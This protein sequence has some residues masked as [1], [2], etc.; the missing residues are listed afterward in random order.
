MLDAVAPA[1]RKLSGGRGRR[2]WLAIAL[3]VL[4]A[5]A[6]LLAVQLIGSGNGPGGGG[7]LSGKG[8]TVAL[9]EASDYD[10]QGDGQEDPETVSF[11]V[12]GDPTTTAWSSEHY[13]TDDLRRHQDRPQPRGRPLRGRR[14]RPPPRAR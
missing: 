14:S 12:D 1:E 10:P 8:S 6:V 2:S 7:A 9:S 5:A 13:D 3:L 11:A 4:V